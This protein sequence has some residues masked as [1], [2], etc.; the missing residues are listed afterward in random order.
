MTIEDALLVEVC[1]IVMMSFLQTLV[2]TAWN[3]EQNG[4]SLPIQ[5]ALWTVS[6]LLHPRE[7]HLGSSCL[8]L[9]C[10]GW[11]GAGDML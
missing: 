7:V 11:R 5:C 8:P 1:G 6:A 2:K 10:D 9:H 4:V 3:L